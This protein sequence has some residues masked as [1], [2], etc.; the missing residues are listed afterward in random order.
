MGRLNVDCVL[1]RVCCECG[2]WTSREL[3]RIDAPL[4]EPD[5]ARSECRVDSKPPAVDHHVMM[6]PTQG[7]QVLRIGRPTPGPRDLVV[8][9][10]SVAAEAPV[11]GAASVTMEDKTAEFVGTLCPPAKRGDRPTSGSG[12]GGT[13]QTPLGAA[14]ATPVPP[15]KGGDKQAGTSPRPCCFETPGGG[16][17]SGGSV[18]GDV[19]TAR[20]PFPHRSA[21]IGGRQLLGVRFSNIRAGCDRFG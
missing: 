2:K 20:H 9:L 1:A 3:G 12:E 4:D 7:R 6:K 19:E 8:W 15:S 14:V 13:V 21:A 11:G 18:N 17:Q 10:Q 16:G 5:P